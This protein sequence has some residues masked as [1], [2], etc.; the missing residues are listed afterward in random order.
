MLFLHA[1]DDEF[2]GLRQFFC[3]FRGIYIL[4][5]IM[6]LKTELISNHIFYF[7]QLIRCL[8]ANKSAVLNCQSYLEALPKVK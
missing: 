4:M 2:L 7:Q 5:F 8:N 1:F 6:E 3:V